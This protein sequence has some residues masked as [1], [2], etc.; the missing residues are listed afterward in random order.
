MLTNYESV[1]SGTVSVAA[2]NAALD[3]ID[4][5]AAPFAFRALPCGSALELEPAVRRHLRE[6]RKLPAR[7]AAWPNFLVSAAGVRRQ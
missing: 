2:L 7:L 3:E 1:G 6:G 4:T 5:D